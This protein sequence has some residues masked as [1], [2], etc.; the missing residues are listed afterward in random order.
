YYMEIIEVKDKRTQKEFLQLPV[1]LYK[2][3]KNWIRP[4]DK[5][6]EKVFDPEENKFFQHGECTRWI[7]MKNGEVI[8]RV[9]AFIDRKTAFTFEQ[10]TGGMGFF[11]CID[12]Q[13]A[14]FK[15]FDTC[16]TWLEERDM[17]AM[18]GPIN[19]GDRLNWW[20]LLVNG[21]YEPNY[22]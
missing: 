8:G 1:R 11:E 10:P 4:L 2:N 18:D 20:G 17:E 14:A 16:K 22:C 5:D 13:E 15:L 19:F 3:D 6:I 12:D 21:F 7:L 9:A